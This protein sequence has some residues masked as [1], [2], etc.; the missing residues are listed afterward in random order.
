M[1]G[2]LFA[3]SVPTRAVEWLP[4]AGT[5]RPAISG[6]VDALLLWRDGLADRPLYFDSANPA[7]VPLD[8]SGIGTGMAAGP[9]YAIE[10]SRDGERALEVNYFSVGDF[11]GSRAVASPAGGLEQADILGFSF[12]DVIAAGAASASAIKSFELN[13]RLPLGRFDGDFLYG[14][15]WVEWNDGFGAVDV[16]ETGAQTGADVFLSE[17]VSSLYGAQLGLDLVLLGSRNRAWVESVGKAGVF[18]TNAVQNSFVESTS[19]SQITRSTAASV[20]TTSFMGELGFT[21]CVRLSDHWVA[22]T[23][24]TMFWLGNVAAAAD[25]FSANNLFSQDI[26]SGI[27][28]GAKVFLYGLNLGLEAGW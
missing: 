3:V 28:T 10:W 21:G 12:P 9:R 14:F 7:I 4:A 16:T 13:R 6:S 1:P 19:V 20:G 23:G 8:A 15:R 17:T 24:F 22:R 5:D 11:T 2:L 26:V 18:G 27:D 25:Q